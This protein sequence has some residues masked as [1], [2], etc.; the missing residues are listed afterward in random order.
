MLNRRQLRVKVMQILYSFYQGDERG[1]KGADQLL[2]KSFESF[3][4]LYFTMLGL[5]LEIRDYAEHRIEENKKKKLPTK[6]DLN[7]NTR[8]IDAEVFKL[9][10]SDVRLK[11]FLE[12]PVFTWGEHKSMIRQMYFAFRETETYERFMSQEE[13]DLKAEKKMLETFFIDIIAPNETL[14]YHLEEHNVFWADDMPLVN[15]MM[16]KT[17]SFIKPGKEGKISL[18]L[19]KEA[20]DKT[21]TRKLLHKALLEDE[22]LEDLVVSKADN[23]EKDRIA[24]MDMILMKMAVCEMIHFPS[25]PIKVSI[26]EYIEISKDYSSPKSKV[27]INGVLDKLHKELKS[28][29]RINKSGRGLVN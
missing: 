1:L 26:N 15:S 11:N 7:P 2:E 24:V 28:S 19:F 8:F 16:L 21:F 23:W 14:H 29:D 5:M 27:F 13:T 6:A 10:E 17:F 3:N 20:E 22:E 4:Q 12:K 18:H 9:I 25:I